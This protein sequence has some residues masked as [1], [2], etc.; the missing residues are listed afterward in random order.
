MAL[1]KNCAF[2]K[3]FCNLGVIFVYLFAFVYKY[4]IELAK[5]VFELLNLLLFI[6]FSVTKKV[7][8]KCRF[9]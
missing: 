8:K 1:V 5:N 2:L 6:L 3:K 4:Q 7:F 9:L